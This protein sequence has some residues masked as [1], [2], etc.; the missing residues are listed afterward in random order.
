MSECT[1]DCS[2]CSENCASR[3]DPKDLIMEQNENSNIII[4]TR[5]SFYLTVFNGDSS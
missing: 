4:S 1:H 2:S 3:Q 5:N